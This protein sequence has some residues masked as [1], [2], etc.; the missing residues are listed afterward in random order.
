M[1][2]FLNCI[3]INSAY[4]QAIN[5][6]STAESFYLGSELINISFTTKYCCTKPAFLWQSTCKIRQS[7]SSSSRILNCLDVQVLDRSSI[8]RYAFAERLKLVA[9]SSHI[10]YFAKYGLRKPAFLW[11]SSGQI[12]Q[13]L[14][15]LSRF[16]N[17]VKANFGNRS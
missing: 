16:R 17:L 7:L 13:S 4:V 2:R 10:G 6:K 12:R 8:V 14:T 5:Q 1:N 11:Q 9:E 3:N 15:G